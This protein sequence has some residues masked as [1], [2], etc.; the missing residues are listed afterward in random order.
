MARRSESI[1]VSPHLVSRTYT[2]RQKAMYIRGP[3]ER[4]RCIRT[5][6][7]FSLLP[8]HGELA[9]RGEERCVFIMGVGVVG[10][11]VVF[12]KKVFDGRVLDGLGEFW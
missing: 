2:E 7:A 6:I 5:F 12:L 1:S 3:E 4:S 11:L 8:I 9:V 10:D